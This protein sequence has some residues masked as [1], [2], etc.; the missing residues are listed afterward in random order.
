VAMK[1][2]PVV[3][4]VWKEYAGRASPGVDPRVV[5][6]GALGLLQVLHRQVLLHW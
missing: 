5:L 4:G 3:R 6:R 2:P 1:K